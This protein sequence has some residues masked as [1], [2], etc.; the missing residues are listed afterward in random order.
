M[1]HAHDYERPFGE[2]WSPPVVDASWKTHNSPSG[3]HWRKR[4]RRIR[5]SERKTS[6]RCGKAASTR[7]NVSRTCEVMI[8]KWHVISAT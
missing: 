4:E 6:Y 3:L 8:G 2:S 5:G 7:I 1:T